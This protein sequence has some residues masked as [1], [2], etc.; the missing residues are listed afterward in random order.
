MFINFKCLYLL[1]YD[2]HYQME[3]NKTVTGKDVANE[4]GRSTSTGSKMLSK[5]RKFYNK[6]HGEP[7][8][9]GQFLKANN[10]EA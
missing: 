5:A 10:L 8:T 7:I 1:K 4:M 6:K 2:N 9:W 3:L